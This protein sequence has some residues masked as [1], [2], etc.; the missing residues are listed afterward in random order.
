MGVIVAIYI[1][2]LWVAHLHPIRT[3]AFDPGFG[4]RKGYVICQKS[5]PLRLFMEL[6]KWTLSV[7]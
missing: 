6:W 7:V 3:M 4:D 1:L 5:G 2:L